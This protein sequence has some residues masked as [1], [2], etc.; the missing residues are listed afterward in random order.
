VPGV[1]GDEPLD[2]YPLY[3]EPAGVIASEVGPVRLTAASLEADL[4][5]W[6]QG[7]AQAGWIVLGDEMVSGDDQSSL[8]GFASREHGNVDF[9]PQL[10]FEYA[11]SA[12]P[13]DFNQ[14][15]RLDEA[16]LTLLTTATLT[17][18]NLAYDLNHD[19]QLN[20]EDRRIWVEELKNSWFGD[21]DLNGQFDT[22]DMTSVFQIG[23]YEDI[24]AGNST[25]S[26]GD[27]TGDFEFDSN[28]FVLAFQGGGYE[29]GPRL[30]A[31]VVPEPAAW[32]LMTVALPGIRW[33]L[34]RMP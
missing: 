34:R 33:S 2:P 13:G 3:G 20:H 19:G 17:G 24:E 25:W 9:R 23:E 11:L 27:W 28:D 7:T 22:N 10:H 31:P 30:A 4:R 32:L 1:L 15:Q 29:Q 5:S 12:L 26:E 14:D 8:R 16:D 18:S 21:A 6:L